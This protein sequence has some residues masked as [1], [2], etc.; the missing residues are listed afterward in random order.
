M[1]LTEF[2]G[3]VAVAGASLMIFHSANA[4]LLP[5]DKN[6]RA[7]E[8]F[9]KWCLEANLDLTAIDRLATEAKYEVQENRSIPM[10]NGQ[11]FRQKNWLIPIGAGEAPILLS[12]NDVTNG[13]I[14]VLGCGIYGPEL[15]GTIMEDLLSKLER[16]GQPTK[17]PQGPQG[18]TVWWRA[19]VGSH[20]PSDDTE[21][22]LSRGIPQMSGAS[23]NLIYKVH[24]EEKAASP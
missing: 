6:Q 22:M 21:V 13:P 4:Q 11:F 2:P 19:H 5:V 16:M 18:T 24:S 20:A 14:H 12:S 9:N 1:R 8:I 7:A 17:H 10:P 3:L 23:E 15:D